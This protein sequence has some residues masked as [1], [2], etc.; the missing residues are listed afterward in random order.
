[1]IFEMKLI[2]T[3]Q[4]IFLI[5]VGIFGY[6]YQYFMTKALQL[7]SVRIISPLIY[8]SVIIGGC[9]GWLIWGVTPSYFTLVELSRL[10]RR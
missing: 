7:A 6:G 2:D 1:M 5:G 4:W 3:Y 8:I 10:Q 9:F